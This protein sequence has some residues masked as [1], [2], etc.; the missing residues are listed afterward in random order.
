MS[1]PPV[2]S[3]YLTTDLVIWGSR[4]EVLGPAFDALSG[5]YWGNGEAQVGL[6]ERITIMLDESA[7]ELEADVRTLLSAIAALHP[8][9][10]EAWAEARLC[11]LSPG[12]QAGNTRS[13]LALEL[14]PD[15]LGEM[16]AFG[17]TLEMV[18]Y[19]ANKQYLGDRE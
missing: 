7:G 5:V 17:L 2:A 11:Q 15:V 18:T 19:P 14:P 12:V 3:R 1:T 16:A 13:L 10:A 9:A 8:A 4:A 6:T